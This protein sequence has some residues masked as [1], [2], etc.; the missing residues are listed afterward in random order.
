MRL[1]ELAERLDAPLIGAE[2]GDPVIDDVSTIEEGGSS[3]LSF[4]TGP[5]YAARAKQSAVGA[6]LVPE[7]MV[8]QGKPC[9]ACS[10]VWKAVCA[11]IAIFHPAREFA[12][13]VHPLAVVDPTVELG[14]G[15][16]VLP[17]AVIEAG[18]RI[19]ARTVIE[20]GVHVGQGAVIGQ[21]CRL[22]PRCVVLDR[23]V[24]G[25]RVIVQPGAVI[26][27]DGFKYEVIDQ[28]ITKIP[29]VGTVVIEDDVEIGANACIDRAGFT[30]T[31]IGQGTK[32]DNLVQIAHNDDVGQS[33]LIV[34]QVGLAGSVK[35][36]D[37]VVLAGQVGVADNLEIGAGTKVGAQSG[38]PKSVPAGSTLFGTP[39]LPAVEA[40]KIHSASKRLP[41][42]L[43]EMRALRR[44][45]AELE[46]KFS[47]DQRG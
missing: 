19:G 4:I 6:L 26:G 21:D 28:R 18:A 36:G 23:C 3:H 20:S 2:A 17:L 42:L 9:I 31:R 14:E 16:C 35:V 8:I 32:I 15:V 37:G 43:E 47:E 33:C 44:R 29:Q 34:A 7:G 13:G 24:L 38:I 5:K 45:I 41:A 40:M 12:P 22:M 1:S 30:R 46:A 27:S 11:V 10:D 39:A 25:D